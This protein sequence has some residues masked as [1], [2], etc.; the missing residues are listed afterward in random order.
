MFIYQ[1]HLIFCRYLLGDWGHR[2]VTPRRVI[3]TR[4]IKKSGAAPL[5]FRMK[6]HLRVVSVAAGMTH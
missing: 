6:E 5:K 2:L 4:N 1:F 3:D